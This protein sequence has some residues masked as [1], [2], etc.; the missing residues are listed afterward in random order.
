[1]INITRYYSFGWEELLRFL[2]NN[3]IGQDDHTSILLSGN[4][5]KK[6]ADQSIENVADLSSFNF[7]KKSKIL[8]VQ[9]N[10]LKQFFIQLH[11]HIASPYV[12]L[13][14]NSDINVTQEYAQFIDDKITHWFAQNL[15][16]SHSKAT[17]LPIGLENYALFCRQPL[18]Y[19]TK[20]KS[21]S[22]EKK[23]LIFLSV[24]LENNILE[25][26]ECVQA[27]RDLPTV[28]FSSLKLPQRR[29]LSTLSK[30][31]F[32]ACPAGNGIDT[33]RLWETLYLG[34]V[35]IVLDSTFA[36]NLES[37]G[38]PLYITKKWSDLATITP[39]QLVE[40]YIELKKLPYRDK[41][42]VTFWQQL[43]TQFV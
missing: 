28:C 34:A 29:Y 19:F 13:S 30:T 5:F 41:L 3:G 2:R 23:L 7:S 35:P 20:L 6:M 17:S 18:W 40:R 24:T 32:V 37:L 36:R 26:S 27:L 42:T 25:R 43:V 4:S 15:L 14:H 22:Q 1:M 9:T 16:F 21:N 38:Y 12:L 33:H 39:A 11:P 10:L 31:L 8:F